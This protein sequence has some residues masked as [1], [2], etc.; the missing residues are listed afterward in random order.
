MKEVAVNVNLNNVWVT[1]E[2][3]MRAIKKAGFQNIFIYWQDYKYEDG[4]ILTKVEQFELAKDLGLNVINVH[5]VTSRMFEMWNEHT[6][7]EFEAKF[8]KFKSDIDAMKKCGIK[9]GI[10][11]IN[12]GYEQTANIT[13]VGLKRLGKMIDYAN[14]QGVQIA[15]EN[16]NDQPGGYLD[17]AME[18]FREK[19]VGLCFDSGHA[20][21]N[22][23]GKYFNFDL[24]K[25][26][27]YAV[28]LHDNIGRQENND[29][30]GDRDEHLLPFDG[31]IDFN[32]VVKKLTQN[33]YNSFVTL[34]MWYKK[35]YLNLTLEEFYKKAYERA[36]KLKAMFETV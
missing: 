10:T 12:G 21:C 20:N 6:I 17:V 1:P 24:F 16:A 25:D 31:K 30:D 4:R 14:C 15:M 28:H 26:R 22:R 27:I 34:E 8:D 18:S 23:Y 13:R 5:I 11:H 35:P 32:K 7:E 2:E 19:N 29:I 33:S 36:V 9:L 3:S